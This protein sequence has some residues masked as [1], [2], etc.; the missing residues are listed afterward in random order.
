MK[1]KKKKEILRKKEKKIRKK[2][3]FQFSAEVHISYNFHSTISL[4]GSLCRFTDVG[5]TDLVGV[6]KSFATN[7]NKHSESD[8]LKT[9]QVT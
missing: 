9:L 2:E 6:F 4:K 5:M 8:S 3:I 1:K 7:T